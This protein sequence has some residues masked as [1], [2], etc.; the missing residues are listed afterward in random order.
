[1]CT[2]LVW[3]TRVAYPSFP[4][5]QLSSG[6]PCPWSVCVVVPLNLLCYMYI[7]T[8]THT[9]LLILYSGLNEHF[10]NIVIVL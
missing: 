9:N 10:D 1:M 7:C 6:S 8:H 2:W 5:S 3:Q 4:L